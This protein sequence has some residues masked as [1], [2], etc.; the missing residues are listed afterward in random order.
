MLFVTL[1]SVFS[2][3]LGYVWHDGGPGSPGYQPLTAVEPPLF[4]W[5]LSCLGLSACT[6]PSCII[7]VHFL[8]WFPLSAHLAPVL[9]DHISLSAL[10]LPAI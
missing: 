1:G 2:L 5:A 6:S 4:G 9:S 8:P 7:L 3:S 10:D